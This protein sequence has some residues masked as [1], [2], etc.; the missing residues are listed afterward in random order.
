MT[1]PFDAFKWNRY[2]PRLSLKISNLPAIAVS[3]NSS[4]ENQEGRHN[5]DPSVAVGEPGR[6]ALPQCTGHGSPLSL[7]H[8]PPLKCIDRVHDVPDLRFQ[9]GGGSLDGF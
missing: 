2:S 7:I 4:P 9:F 8:D 5:G 6:Q 1:S 3:F